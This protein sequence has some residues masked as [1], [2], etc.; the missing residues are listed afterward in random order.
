MSVERLSPIAEPEVWEVEEPRPRQ[1]SPVEWE[2]IEREGLAPGRRG[3]TC[4]QYY[5]LGDL[6]VLGPHERVELVDGRILS[7][8]PQ[9]SYHATALSLGFQ[10]L[11][12]IFSVGCY[13]RPQQPLSHLP[14]SEPEPDLAVVSG[15]PEDYEEAHPGTAV[16]VLEVSDTT[17]RFDLGDKAGLYAAMGIQDYWVTD[18]RGRRV[19][20]HREPVPSPTAKHGFFYAQRQSYDVDEMIEPLAAPGKSVP[21]KALLPS[22]LRDKKQ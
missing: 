6:G 14:N 17:L 20:V 5:R 12:E 21:V 1:F 9:K 19:V 18:L 3:W 22:K 2:V 10:A 15:T 8:S 16:L 4:D 13:I 7:L 11:A